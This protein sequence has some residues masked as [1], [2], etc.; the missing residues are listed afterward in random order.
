[1]YVYVYIYIFPGGSDGKESAF[2][3][4]NRGS[5][6]GSGRSPGG[7]KGNPLQY[8]GLENCM[9]RGA[10]WATVHKV[11]FVICD[12]CVRGS[13]A[14]GLLSRPHTQLCVSKHVTAFPS[15]RQDSWTSPHR[16]SGAPTRDIHPCGHTA[17]SCPISPSEAPFRGA[18]AWEVS[19]L[20][21]WPQGHWPG[22][23]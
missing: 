4:G 5:I 14:T 1:M 6:P 13:G 12:P 21:C 7:G 3:A 23:L 19:M 22:C 8:S 9:N 18:G 15:G 17:R 16:P 2:S 10:R 11:G 20:G